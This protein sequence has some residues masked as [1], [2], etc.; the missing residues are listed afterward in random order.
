[1]TVGFKPINELCFAAE[2]LSGTAAAS[3]LRRLGSIMEHAPS[4]RLFGAIATLSDMS[5]RAAEA[6]AE[7][8]RALERAD[9]QAAARRIG[10]ALAQMDGLAAL[11]GE[12]AALRA[13]RPRRRASR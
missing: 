10:E 4:G 5:A 8:S 2:G 9:D 3:S 13:K 6:L 1:M 11:A 12:P 7:G